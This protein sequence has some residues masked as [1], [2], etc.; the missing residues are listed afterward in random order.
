MS[1]NWQNFL[2][3]AGMISWVIDRASWQLRWIMDRVSR[4]YFYTEPKDPAS[5][6]KLGLSAVLLGNLHFYLL[7]ASFV[8]LFSLRLLPGRP[9]PRQSPS[10]LTYARAFAWVGHHRLPQ[11]PVAHLAFAMYA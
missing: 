11:L 5:L 1:L 8:R 2:L 4:F 3:S 9:R 10:S 7:G 6:M